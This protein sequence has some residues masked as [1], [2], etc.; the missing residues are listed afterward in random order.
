LLRTLAGC[1]AK[2]AVARQGPDI[3]LL[4]TTMH[5]AHYGRR[6]YVF[7]SPVSRFAF[8]L[9]GA[10]LFVGN[11][12]ISEYLPQ[13]GVSPG[14][15]FSPTAWPRSG[16]RPPETSDAKGNGMSTQSPRGALTAEVSP[17][18]APGGRRNLAAADWLFRS[19]AASV[20]WL[21][22]R[23]W[24][25]YGWLNAG[26]QKLWGSEKAFFWNGGGAGVQGFATAGVAGSRA[27][28][29]GASYGW[30]A[31]FSRGFVIP[32]A[33]WIARVVSVSE[34]VIGALL[35]LGLFTGAVAVAVAGVALDVVYMF[36]GSS[37]VNPA[38]AI[39]AVFLVLAWRNAGYLG[40]DRLVLPMLGSRFRPGR[41]P[42]TPPV[43]SPPAVP[44][45]AS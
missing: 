4:K 45:P 24:L 9:A 18:G 25:G 40:L 7:G 22:G 14:R 21:V 42:V 15:N 37:G 31:G 32:N 16:G 26:Y 1:P 5:A 8:A 12:A 35:I 30:F 28:T 2:F 27:G 33:S 43:V 38:Y 6:T 10:I 36:S 13:D 19:R 29:G 41:R 20:L 17:F 44:A 39:V 3:F 34:L 23:V 11:H